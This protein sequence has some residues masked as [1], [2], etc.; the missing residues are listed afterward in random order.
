MKV[1]S[2]DFAKFVKN[3]SV[4]FSPYKKIFFS[5][6]KH[7]DKICLLVYNFIC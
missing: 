2:S 3:Y 1:F 6:T 5:P 4:I 7:L